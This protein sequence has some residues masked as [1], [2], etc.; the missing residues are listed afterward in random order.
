MRVPLLTVLLCLLS[1][2]PGVLLA[3]N[4]EEVITRLKQQGTLLRLKADYEAANRVSDELKRRF[5]D[6]SIGYTINLN[7]LVTR[8]SWDDQQS[9]YDQPILEDAAIALDL[10]QEQIKKNPD[11]YHGY[12]YCG[13][14]HFALTYLHALR[15]NYYRAGKN[16][17][18]TIDRLEQALKLNPALIDAKMH[19]GVAYYYADNLPPFVKAFSRYLWFVPTGNSSKSLPYIREV[20]EK[21]QYFQ[22]VAK[23]IYSDLLIDGDEVDQKDALSILAELVTHY[24]ENRRF[25]FRY[26]SL[27][28]SLGEHQRSL[29]AASEFVDSREQYQRSPFDITLVQLWITRAQLGLKNLEGAISAFGN[30][31]QNSVDSHFPSWGKSW[32]L[33]TEAQLQD[34]QHQR[35]KALATY[36][37]IIRLFSRT[38][39]PKLLM[40][41]Q[42]GLE[43]PFTF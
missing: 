18:D 38:G 22:D 9:Q 20:T 42:K 34:L 15:G 17:S 24:P 39:N 6:H 27:L 1:T 33:L 4:D 31:E 11:D 26:I 37:Q 35:T 32:F 16:G 23:F 2:R 12:Y 13:Q 3:A 7:T 43:T 14:A 29:D 8:L 5:P 25:Q 30:I 19:L 21:G 10:C 36:R 41:A 28:E 40:A